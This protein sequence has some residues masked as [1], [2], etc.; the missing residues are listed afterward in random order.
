MQRYPEIKKFVQETLGCACP[1]EVFENIVYSENANTPWERR[2][3][4]GNRLLVY[5]VASDP[6]E[7]TSRKIDAALQTGVIERNRKGFNRFRLVL[8]SPNRDEDAETVCEKLFCESPSFDEKT[9]LHIVAEKDAL[10][11]RNTSEP[12]GPECGQSPP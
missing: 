1:E 7:S 10:F 11:F 5:V 3:E 6:L 2:I 9:H 12:T 8:V 4:V